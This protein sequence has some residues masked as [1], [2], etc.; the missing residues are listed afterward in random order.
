M[1]IIEGHFE[2]Q[3]HIVPACVEFFK[4]KEERYPKNGT[5][6]LVAGWGLNEV[7]KIVF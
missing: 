3:L 4:K 2:Y 6:A 1:V 7:A 5:M